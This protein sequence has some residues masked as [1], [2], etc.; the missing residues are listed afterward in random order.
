[1]VINRLAPQRRRRVAFLLAMAVPVAALVLSAGPTAAAP[2]SPAATG[3]PK[4][5]VGIHN[6]P[7]DVHGDSTYGTVA[8]MAIP[9]GRW[10][11]TATGYLQST[12]LTRASCQLVAGSDT[13]RATNSFDSN[14]SGAGQWRAFEVMTTHRFTV[15]GRVR[16]DCQTY[17]ETGAVL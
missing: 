4:V 7:T 14:T 9:A 2:A 6:G 10:F 16:L 13:N 8:Q 15:A 3:N 17:V 5:L 11:I 1:M 12:P